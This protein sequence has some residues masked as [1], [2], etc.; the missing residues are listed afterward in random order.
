MITKIEDSIIANAGPEAITSSGCKRPS[1]D[2]TSARFYASALSR[3][4]LTS[5]C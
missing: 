1:A 5:F 3:H 4:F 2:G